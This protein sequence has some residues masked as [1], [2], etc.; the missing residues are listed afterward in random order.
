M[1]YGKAGWPFNHGVKIAVYKKG[2]GWKRS[3]SNIHCQRNSKIFRKKSNFD[4]FNTLYFEY[5][6]EEN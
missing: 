2:E 6:F 5:E 3:G 4:S 1:N